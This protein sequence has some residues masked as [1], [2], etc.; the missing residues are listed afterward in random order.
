MRIPALRR[1]KVV[2]ATATVALT[3]LVFGAAPALAFDRLANEKTM[4]RLFNQAR[5]SRGLHAVRTYDALRRAAR[6][7]STDMLRRDYF[8]HSSL[9]GLTAGARARQAGYG[10]SGWSQWSVGEVIAWGTGTLGS[11]QAI[12]KAWMKSSGH[13]SII[14]GKRWRD[15][16][17][18]CSRGTFKGLS[19]VRMWTVDFGRRVQ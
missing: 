14:L 16:G 9:S 13:R 8:A 19:G 6:A 5:T 10:V 2:L 7:H 17:V 15:V 18:G 1:I 12:F 11:P 4:L 3:L